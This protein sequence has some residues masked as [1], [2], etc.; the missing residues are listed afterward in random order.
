MDVKDQ[1]ARSI[2][3]WRCKMYELV[4]VV[5]ARKYIIM[6]RK[7]MDG[8]SEERANTCMMAL[9]VMQCNREDSLV[10]QC[11]ETS[12]QKLQ[13]CNVAGLLGSGGVC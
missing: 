10:Q 6:K 5:Q 11:K 8:E 7:N 2:E 12:S 13:R 4:W 3:Q 9:H 1:Q